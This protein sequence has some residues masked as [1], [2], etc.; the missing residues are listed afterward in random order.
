MKFKG[1]FVAPAALALFAVPAAAQ[2]AAAPA[3]AS[4]SAKLAAGAT[5]YDTSGGVVGT[6]E[7]VKGDLAVLATEKSKVSI[8]VASFGTGEKGPVLALTRDQ[9][10]A[11]A[12]AA[13]A[14]AAQAE[15]AK[16]KAQLVAG[17][18]VKDP[19]GG[20]VGTIKSVDAQFALV[21]T[22][23]VQVRLPLSAFAAGEGGPV[24]G[25]TKEQLDAQAAAAAPEAA[26]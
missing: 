1:W 25:M 4:T 11:Q 15:D 5:V 6:I 18:T 8:P 13:N 16:K 23:N 12:G 24:I 17:A 20:T 21:D 2:T 9:I 3:A 22:S 19:A 26:Q 7:S 10:D 14:E